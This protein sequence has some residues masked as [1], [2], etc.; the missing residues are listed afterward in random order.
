MSSF[1]DESRY[2]DNPFRDYSDLDLAVPSVDKLAV[3]EQLRK[4]CQLVFSYDGHECR[5]GI[6]TGAAGITYSYLH[7]RPAL[8]EHE[9]RQLLPVAQKLYNKHI[10]YY[11]DH[12]R[13]L[14]S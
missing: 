5:G 4:T 1:A 8:S 10:Q 13:S 2:F 9:S 6:Y 11:E 3:K 7:I 12:D 14:K